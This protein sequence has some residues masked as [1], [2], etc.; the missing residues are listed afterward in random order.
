MYLHILSDSE[1]KKLDTYNKIIIWGFPLHTHTHSYIHAMWYKVFKEGFEK[2]TYWFDDSNYPTDF[3]YNNCL[4]I[5]EGYADKN[6][7]LDRSSTYFV[8]VCI[9]PG[10]FITFVTVVS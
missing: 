7:P 3:D 8:H 1:K 4:F 2:E 9:N 10:K 6:I 5:S